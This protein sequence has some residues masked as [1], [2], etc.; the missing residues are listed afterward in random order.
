MSRFSKS[1]SNNIAKPTKLGVHYLSIVHDL[2]YVMREIHIH[3]IARAQRDR[4][5]RKFESWASL[6]RMFTKFRL[7]HSS[8]PSGGRSGRSETSARNSSRI[9]A[10]S[11]GGVGVRLTNNRC[12]ERFRTKM[13]SR[14]SRS[15]GVDGGIP[16]SGSENVERAIEMRVRD[17]GITISGSGGERDDR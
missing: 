14:A 9:T 12:F 15:A 13:V 2:L 8:S 16:L 11:G 10:G 6:S 17:S 5:A 4:G 7:V 3:C 1:I